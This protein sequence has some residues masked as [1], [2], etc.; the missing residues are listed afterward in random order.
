MISSLAKVSF[1]QIQYINPFNKKKLFVSKDGLK[2]EDGTLFPF[3]KGAYRFVSMDNYTESFGFQW[4][5]FQKTQIDKESE[6]S[7]SKERFFAVTG[8]DSEDLTGKSVLEVGSGAGRFSQIVLEDTAA[9]LYSVDYSTAVEA[10]YKNNGPNKRLVLFQSSIYELPFDAN[11]FDKVFCFGVLQHTPDFRESIK[12]LVDMVK[13]DGELVVDFYPIRGW[14]TKIHAKYLLRPFV[15]KIAHKK[16]L[17][18]INKN[19]D[20]LIGI[21]QFFKKI[22]LYQIANRFVPICDLRTL[23]SGLSQESYREWVILDT[24]D[25]FSPEYDNPQKLLTVKKWFEEFG[26]KDVVAEY[27]NYGEDNKVAVVK[28]FK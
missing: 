19:V 3:V 4:N 28:G 15:K 27:V 22:G 7:I 8:W 10:N 26:M 12:S 9:N 23:P 5:S 16:L 24:F 17:S 21:S 20:W 1:M 18:L 11:S 14:W 13:D 6:I 25:M 2:D